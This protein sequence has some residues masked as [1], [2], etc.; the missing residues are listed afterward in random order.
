MCVEMK[1]S[2][3]NHR[4]KSI[5]KNLEITIKMNQVNLHVNKIKN[6]YNNLY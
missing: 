3:T 1:E 6:K 2:S 5:K 4:I